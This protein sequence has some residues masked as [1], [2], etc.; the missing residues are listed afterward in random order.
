MNRRLDVVLRWASLIVTDR[1]WAAPL[2]A[3]ALGFG[4]F[5]GVAIG[6]SA[7]GTLAT[8]VQPII[9]I[10]GFIGGTSDDGE[11]GDSSAAFAAGTSGDEEGSIPSS[12]SALPSFT[13]IPSSPAVPP[14]APSP[15]PNLAIAN[16]VAVSQPDVPTE[17]EC[18]DLATILWQIYADDPSALPF[19]DAVGLQGWICADPSVGLAAR[20]IPLRALRF[21]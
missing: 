7:P 10:P 8:G 12:G 13:P 9:E 3:L 5:A 19:A 17:A 2:S 21:R 14:P 16:A 1:R 15:E 20:P 6:P 11:D 4:L 18:V